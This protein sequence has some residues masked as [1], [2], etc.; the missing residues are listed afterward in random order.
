MRVAAVV[1]AAGSARRMG[2]EKL[3][4]AFDGRTV[5]EC[6]LAPYRAAKG[7][8]QVVIV[9]RPDFE[10][11]AS[12]E[13]V[14]PVRCQEHAEGMGASL[15]AGVAASDADAWLI[16]LGD[17]PRLTA[18]TVD[19]LVSALAEGTNS[20]V[21]PVHDGRRGHPVGFSRRW[22][23]A[24]LSV[25]GDQGARGILAAHADAVHRV[26]VDDP[27]ALFDIDVPADLR[28]EGAS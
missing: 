1:L 11:A 6:A 15:R 2:A 27:G 28:R 9:L 22:R 12:L 10:P 24:L 19:A 20:I 5:L 18:S 16:G 23:E 8:A 26:G 17:M 4:L 7:L 13:G 21:A 3:N 14:R 25:R